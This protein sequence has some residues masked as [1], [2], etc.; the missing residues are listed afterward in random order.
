MQSKLIIAVMY[1]NRE[2]YT[3]VKLILIEKFKE[4]TNESKEYDFDKFTSY[5]EEEMGKNLV[6]RFLIFNYFIEKK[7]LIKIKKQTSEIEK[8]F[9]KDNKRKINL[10][11]GCLNDKELFL[12]SF[13]KGT[14]YKEDLGQ[15][16]Y[17]HKVLEFK[18]GKANIFRHTFSDYR[19]E[20]NQEFFI[21]RAS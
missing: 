11:P 15:G 4:I 2:I 20:E 6:K 1:S 3:K 5:Y 10:D 17:A 16:V 19:I 9:S 18:E 21:K 12:A 7:D 8:E 13:K 14:N